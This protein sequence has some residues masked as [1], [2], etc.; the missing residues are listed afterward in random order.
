MIKPTAKLPLL[1]GSSMQNDQTCANPE[2]GCPR[3]TALRVD[4]LKSSVT[5]I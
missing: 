4:G 2:L 1:P 3:M 5:A